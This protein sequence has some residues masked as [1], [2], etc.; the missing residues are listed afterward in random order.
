MIGVFDS[1]VGGLTVLAEIRRRLP[2]A[3]LIY[4]GDHAAAPYGERSLESVADRCRLVSDWLVGEGCRVITVACNTASAAALHSLR[5]RHPDVAFVGMEP[6][7]KP[8]ASTTRAGRVGVVA[9]AATFQG[10]LFA[11]AVERFAADIDVYSAACP[12]WVR[13]VE[14]GQ[15][16]GAAVEEAVERCLRPLIAQRIDVLVLACTHYPALA[17]VIARCLGPE[18][19]IVDPS[20]AVARQ[21]ERVSGPAA[22]GTSQTRLLSTGDVTGLRRAAARLGFRQPTTLL[23]LDEHGPT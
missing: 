22:M 14:E 4:V 19:Q 7:V 2:D 18:V 10:E 23:P 9:T 11:T 21:T 6:A 13:L 17:P 20:P 12:E 16:D 15:L 1:G 5:A 3:D 8:A